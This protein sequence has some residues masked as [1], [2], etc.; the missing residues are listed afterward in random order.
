MTSIFTT[1]LMRRHARKGNPHVTFFLNGTSCYCSY[2]ALLDP[3]GGSSQARERLRAMAVRVRGS[4]TPLLTVQC[5][6]WL[7]AVHGV[8]LLRLPRVPVGD[9]GP[10]ARR[11][12]RRPQHRQHGPTLRQGTRA[13]N[14]PGSSC[15]KSPPLAGIVIGSTAHV[16]LAD[17]VRRRRVR[18]RVRRLRAQGGGHR[19]HRPQP[20]RRDQGAPLAPG[21]RA[22]QVVRN[23]SERFRQLTTA[24]SKL[25]YYILFD[26]IEHVLCR[27]LIACPATS[28]RNGSGS[29]PPRRQGCRPTTPQPPSRT[30]APRW[31]RYALKL[32]TSRSWIIIS[33]TKMSSKGGKKRFAHGVA[34]VGPR[35]EYFTLQ[36]AVNLSLENL[37]TY[38][39]VKEGLEKGTLKLVGGHYDFV[40]GKFETWDP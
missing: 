24:S 40:S 20:L 25:V 38:P 6:S 18:H 34:V 19:G 16:L 32:K 30:N 27:R 28:S 7:C 8:R 37:K 21:R 39:F 33:E 31:K 35:S 13:R 10:A 14:T 17:P 4:A 1:L 36:E 5:H 9:P 29:A 2:I 26:L 22:R 12:L 3:L 11:G 23:L 15:S